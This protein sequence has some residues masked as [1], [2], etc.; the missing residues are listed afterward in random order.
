VPP[1]ESINGD[2]VCASLKEHRL[3]VR[4]R[5]MEVYEVDAGFFGQFPD[6]AHRKGQLPRITYP[7]GKIHVGR[8]PADDIDYFGSA[9]SALIAHDF[10]REQCRDFT[11]RPEI[12]W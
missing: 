7:N 10:S 4:T 11:V 8:N 12:I 2:D 6:A 3:G 5:T 1:V 9:H